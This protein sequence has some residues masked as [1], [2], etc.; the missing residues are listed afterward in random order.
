MS[1]SAQEPRT[2]TEFSKDPKMLQAY[3]D[4]KDLYAI[5]AQ[6]AFHN[7]YWDNMEH[8]EDGSPNPEG[9]KRRGIAKT[10]LLGIMYGRGCASIADQIGCSIPEAQKIIDTFFES[11]PKVKEWVTKTE[12]DAKKLGYVEDYWGRRRRLPDIMKP[13]YTITA[14]GED[15]SISKDFNPLL[16]ALGLVKNTQGTLTEKWQNALSKMKGRKEYE[17]IKLNAAKEGVTIIDNGA[18]IAQ[19]ERQCVNARIQGSAATLTKIAMIEIFND[20]VL[21][22]LGFKLL[23]AVHDELIGECP[24]ENKDKVADR[25]CERMI[26]AAKK[27][28]MSVPFKCDPTIEKSWYFEEYAVLVK[29]EYAKYISNG[30][31]EEVAWSKLCKEHCESTPEQ[32]KSIIESEE[33]E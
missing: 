26:Y 32:L 2:L 16:G 33:A 14:K 3:R 10:L 11:F 30:D 24:E 19:A 25:L 6:Q 31:T 23:I 22:N 12:Q 9:K 20:D 29:K 18:F 27:G 1:K 15:T 4:G 13:K 8:Y 7:G 5:I 28:G 21:K 17:Q